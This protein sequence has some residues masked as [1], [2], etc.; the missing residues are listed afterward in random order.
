VLNLLSTYLSTEVGF[1]ATNALRADLARHCLALDMAF[2][3][4]RTPGEMIERIDGDVT[5]LSNFFSTVRYSTAGQ[6]LADLGRVGGAVPRRLARRPGVD[7][8]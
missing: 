5:A 3:N 1:R 8:F 6:R 2:H 4:E 7:S